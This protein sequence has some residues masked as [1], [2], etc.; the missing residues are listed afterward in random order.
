MT[1]VATGMWGGRVLHRNKAVI[2]CKDKISRN[3][4]KGE[5]IREK[6]TLYAESLM[7]A[8]F[9]LQTDAVDFKGAEYFV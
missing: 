9:L 1:T 3:P 4:H 7:V 6:E 5:I 8:S 2:I